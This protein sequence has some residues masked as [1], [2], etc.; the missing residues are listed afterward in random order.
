MGR[1]GLGG[2]CN[3]AEIRLSIFIQRRWYADNDR[4]H[5][6]QARKV[7][8]CGEA[9]GSRMLDLCWRNPIDVGPAGT[10]SCYLILIDVETRYSKLRLC[11]KQ[12]KRQTHIPETNHSDSRL[13]S[14][15]SGF[16]RREQARAA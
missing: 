8:G 14:I 9:P 12:S 4:V 7:C 5:L 10:Q 2:V 6:G 1:N 15:D 11:V 3:E 13:A 16:Q